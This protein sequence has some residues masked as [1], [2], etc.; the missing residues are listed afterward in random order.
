MPLGR[1]AAK[2]QAGVVRL[3]GPAR[4]SPLGK[5]LWRVEE[6]SAELPRLHAS[7][8][9]QSEHFTMSNAEHQT[10]TKEGTPPRR[11]ALACGSARLFGHKH[12]RQREALWL[13]D[14]IAGTAE[15][16]WCSTPLDFESFT[17]DH[18]TALAKCGSNDLSN[19]VVACLACNQ[20]RG[21]KLSLQ[22]KTDQQHAE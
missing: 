9:W 20:E 2:A 14:S 18:V 12:R 16:F 17:V 4:C 19:L 21:R 7:G 10:L 13:R 15:C 3:H 8:L 22:N 11:C 6:R 1:M 5:P